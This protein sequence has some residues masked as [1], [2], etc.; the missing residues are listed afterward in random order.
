MATCVSFTN[1]ETNPARLQTPS[2]NALVKQ[3]WVLAT[4]GYPR[5]QV[6]GLGLAWPT[7]VQTMLAKSA[8]P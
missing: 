4:G 1:V 3:Q 6:G 2:N 8:S 7:A 5:L